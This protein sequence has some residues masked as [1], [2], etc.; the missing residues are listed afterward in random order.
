MLKRT[1][2]FF[3]ILFVPLY[4]IAQTSPPEISAIGGQNYCI[5]SSVPIVTTVTITDADV[6]DTTL[7]QVFLQIAEGYASGFD[8]LFLSGT[9]PNITSAWSVNQGRLTLT[10]PATFSEFEM[11]IAS[12]E[13]TTTQNV[14]TENRNVSINLGDANFLPSTGHYY[15]YVA[16]FGIAWDAARDAAAAQT[17]F[18]LQGYLATV[19]TVEESQITGEQAEGAGWIGATDEITEGTW[20]WVTGPEAGTTFWQGLSN[21]TPVNGEFSFWNTDEPN[22]FPSNGDEDYAHITDPSIGQ[23]GSWN[24]LPLIGDPNTSS[25]FHPKGYVVEFG[26]L[27]GDPIINLSTSATIAMPQT[28]FTNA[29]AECEDED[30]MLFIDTNTDEI[31]WFDTETST[32][33]INTGNTFTVN[34]NASEDYWIVSRFMGCTEDDRQQLTVTINEKPLASAITIQQCDD[35]TTDGFSTF[36]L[37]NYSFLVSAGITANRLVEYFEDPA[38]TIPI[39][40]LSYTN[41]PNSQLIYARVTDTTSNCFTVAEVTLSVSTITIEQNFTLDVCDDEVEDGIT[42]FDLSLADSTVLDGLPSTAQTRYYTSFDDALLEENTINTYTNTSPNGGDILYVRVTDGLDCLGIYELTLIVSPLPEVRPDETRIYCLNT[43]P[44]TITLNGGIVNDIPNNF[45]YS[46]ST[47]ETTI[48]I[49]INEPETYTV[50]VTE[51]DGCTNRRT[52]TVVPSSI[53]TIDDIVV[54]DASENNSITINATGEGDYEYALNFINGPYQDSNTFE[55]VK[56]GIHT[57]Y[58]NDKNGCGIISQ[59]VTVIGFQNSSRL[60]VMGKMIFG[61]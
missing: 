18:G 22:N 13:F 33:V 14:F 42:E 38:L 44:E 56:S 25:P 15:M 3:S 7:N 29:V 12:V 10:G 37:E 6:A 47:G 9:H 46:W 40:A 17:F 28:T 31:L 59:E 32:T 27:P 35:V 21:G 52:I 1:I 8:T 43:F 48:E 34:L 45:Y 55:N 61:Q 50:D 39:D 57:I 60:T 24:D 53:A 2:L 5:G 36:R 49:E 20:Q 54:I 41:Q 30:I 11:A 26:G 58:I 19:T 16:N 51:V 23:L 4:V